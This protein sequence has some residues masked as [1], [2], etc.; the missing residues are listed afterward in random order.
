MDR[1]PSPFNLTSYVLAAGQVQP[2]KVA[3][4]VLG[5]AQA[6]RWSYARLTR[7]V[8]SVGT[9]LLRAGFQAGDRLVIRLDNTVA[10]PLSYLGAIAVGIVPVPTSAQLTTHEL[11][12]LLPSIAPRGVV[13]GENVPLPT[14]PGLQV[15]EADVLGME[16]LPPAEPVLGDPDRL[17]YIIF[18]SGSSGTPR[19]V[20][21]AHRAVWAR[22]SMWD[23]WYGLTP[24]D[25]MLHAGAFNWTFTLG[26]G[27]LD[28]WTIGAT[29]LIPA[30]GTPIETLPLLLSRHDATLFAAAPGV[31]RKLLKSE[32]PPQLPKLRHG[33]C[34]GEHLLD[35]LRD[36]WVQATGTGLFD[37]YGMTECSTFLSASPR[38][39]QS[40]TPQ[41]GRQ[42]GVRDGVIAI[43][44]TDPGLMLGYVADHGV[45]L[46]LTDGWFLTGDHGVSDQTGRITFQGRG[47]DLMNAGGY[48]VSPLEV[49]A[50][51]AATPGIDDIA[52]AEVQVKDDV[53][54]IAACY[55][56]PAPVDTATFDALATTRLA[57]YKQPRL[58]THVPDLPRGPNGKLR[59][60]ALPALVKASYDQA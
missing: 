35:S 2:D 59:R 16:D 17:A 54:V 30:P 12:R 41:P 29:A 38:G 45:N 25:R 5:P 34:A 56:A 7:A 14:A 48:R 8:L 51:L 37:A 9:G 46:P 50:A 49:E 27:L 60:A 42:V 13:A 55:T 23:G 24:Q 31:F 3:L 44:A 1:C 26:T 18:T 53:T 11:D 39:A 20:A 22:R 15:T 28:P 43:K 10:F 58:Y 47:S 57:R 6:E 4:A 36:R 21:H 52:V 33:L 19:A 40:L 32:H